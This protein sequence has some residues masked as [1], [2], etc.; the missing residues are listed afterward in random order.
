MIRK[1]PLRPKLGEVSRDYTQK[2]R[3]PK[4]SNFLFDCDYEK[5]ES[6]DDWERLCLENDED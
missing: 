3:A 6:H 2:S 4:A 1:R 5:T